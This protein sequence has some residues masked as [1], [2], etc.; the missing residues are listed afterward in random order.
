M[1]EYVKIEVNLATEPYNIGTTF[2]HFQGYKIV[3]GWLLGLVV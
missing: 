2:V 3:R 1:T